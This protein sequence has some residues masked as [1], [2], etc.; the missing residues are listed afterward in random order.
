[1]KDCLQTGGSGMTTKEC[2][3]FYKGQKPIGFCDDCGRIPSQCKCQ[4]K[5]YKQ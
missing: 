3:E 1:M 4:K 2:K 5:V